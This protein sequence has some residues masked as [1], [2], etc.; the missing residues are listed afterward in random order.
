MDIFGI[1]ITINT[2]PISVSQA[3]NVEVIVTAYI[4]P[5]QYLPLLIYILTA[6]IGAAI[7][8]GIARSLTKKKPLPPQPPKETTQPPTGEKTAP[9]TDEVVVGQPPEGYHLKTVDIGQGT[10]VVAEKDGLLPTTDVLWWDRLHHVWVQHGWFKE[11]GDLNHMFN[12]NTGQNAFWDEAKNQW[13][14][15]KTGQPIGYK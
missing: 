15:S 9:S 12:K 4:I 1:P 2:T 5:I 7:I 13:I 6:I 11:P 10:Q 8:Y 14:D 3:T